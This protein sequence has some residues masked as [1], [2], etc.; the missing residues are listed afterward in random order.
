MGFNFPLVHFLSP[1]CLHLV[2]LL[3]TSCPL[4]ASILSSSWWLPVPFLPPS[5]PLPGHF[6]PPSG[7]LLV[8]F[9]VTSC[10]LPGHFLSPFCLILVLFLVTSYP[11]ICPFPALLLSSFFPPPFPFFFPSCLLHLLFLPNCCPLPV[12]FLYPSCLLHAS[13]PMP[14]SFLPQYCPLPVPILSPSY[15]LPVYFKSFSCPLSVLFLFSFCPPWS[16]A[17]F[18]FFLPNVVFFL[19]SCFFFSRAV[20]QRCCF[21]SPILFFLSHAIFPKRS[22]SPIF[23]S[24]FFLLTSYSFFLLTWTPVFNSPVSPFPSSLCVKHINVNRENTFI[25][26]TAGCEKKTNKIL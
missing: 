9:L 5:C 24:P 11:L 14:I 12:P 15:L 22:L 2:L 25:G 16:P 20:F 1:S 21:F 18:L 4:L 26:F 7:L 13:F 19:P 23:F 10:P 8:L 3:V 6:L 17:P